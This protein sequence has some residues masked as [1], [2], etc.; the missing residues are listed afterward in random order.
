MMEDGLL[1]PLSGTQFYNPKNSSVTVKYKGIEGLED[2]AACYSVRRA[3]F[4]SFLLDHV[5]KSEFT[6]VYSNTFIR[7]LKAQDEGYI[8]EGT[9]TSYSAKLIIVAAGSTSSIPQ[10]L[11]MPKPENKHFA[12]GIRAYFKGVHC[13]SDQPE[14]YFDKSVFPGGVYI[15][16]LSK[17]LYNV[18]LVIK[19]DAAIRYNITLEE[20]FYALLECN[21]VLK[22]KFK[23]ATL[24]HPFRGA[25][26][27]L[28]TKNRTVC[29]K[30]FMLVGD[31]AGLIDLLSANGIPQASMSAKL[32][33]LKAKECFEQNNFSA[34]FMHD[35]QEKLH[36][37]VKGYLALGKL[38]NPIASSRLFQFAFLHFIRLISGKPRINTLLQALAYKK[39]PVI[40]LVNPFFYFSLRKQ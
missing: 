39:N 29:G 28:G 27:Y 18:N 35:Y 25:G 17:G 31:S 4:D 7:D 37:R 10:K 2:D 20:R 38:I 33:A 1:S 15:T 32:A 9:Q 11:G 5:R 34:D 6:T 36:K 14:L 22:E 8:L 40:A 30:G 3:E 23:D 21:S 16:P 19:K 13:E 12:L 24:V 26:L